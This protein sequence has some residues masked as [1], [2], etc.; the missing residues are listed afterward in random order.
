MSITQEVYYK[1][2]NASS[3]ELEMILEKNALPKV[4]STL[5]HV[6]KVLGAREKAEFEPHKLEHLIKQLSNILLDQKNKDRIVQHGYDYDKSVLNI[7]N[8]LQGLSIDEIITPSKK[9][10][11]FHSRRF[12]CN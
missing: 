7:I 9:Y 1:P 4:N 11:Q 12:G 6:F 3:K 10:L 2:I 5:A 8:Y